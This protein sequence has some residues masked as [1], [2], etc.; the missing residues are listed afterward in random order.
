MDKASLRRRIFGNNISIIKTLSQN[1]SVL[2]NFLEATISILRPFHY[3]I[4]PRGF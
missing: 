4:I 1:I 2:N 3:S